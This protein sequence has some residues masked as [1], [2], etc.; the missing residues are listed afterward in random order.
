MPEFAG[1][2]LEVGRWRWRFLEADHFVINRLKS[3]YHFNN[4]LHLSRLYM[5][6]D[7]ATTV[8]V[9]VV[10]NFSRSNNSLILS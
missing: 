8:H 1:L 10:I 3:L 5:N 9:I 7:A 6:F 2:E 4:G